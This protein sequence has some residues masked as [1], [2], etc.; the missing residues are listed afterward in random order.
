MPGVSNGVGR[1]ELR[2]ITAWFERVDLVPPGGFGPGSGHVPRPDGNQPDG[3]PINVDQ[4]NGFTAVYRVPGDRACTAGPTSRA[5]FGGF[6]SG[7][8]AA[9]VQSGCY[10]EGGEPGRVS[11]I[12]SSRRGVDR[13]DY[14]VGERLRFP[15]LDLLPGPSRGAPARRC[16][17]RVNSAAAPLLGNVA[18]WLVV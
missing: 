14:G 9:G 15:L 2:C 12:G 17:Y 18:T 8:E 1:C 6:D 13:V 3:S 4:V 11:R 7:G 16:T 5:E 10:F